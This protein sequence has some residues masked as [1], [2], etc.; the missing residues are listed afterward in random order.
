MLKKFLALGHPLRRRLQQLPYY[1]FESFTEIQLA[2]SWGI[3]IEANT[4]ST[5]D[6]LR[7]PGI[8]IHQARLLAQLSTNG[9]SFN[10]I[11]DIAAALGVPVE[12]VRPWEIIL[13]FCYYEAQ[14]ALEPIAVD[15]NT[16]TAEQLTAVPMIDPFLRSRHYSLPQVRAV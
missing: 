1:R 7:L 3:Y 6:W 14:Q 13:R 10:C 2:A 11:E 4:A 5:D 16:A 12:Q 9:L 8:S 15:V